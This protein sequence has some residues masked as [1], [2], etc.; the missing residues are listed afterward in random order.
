LKDP[1]SGWRAHALI[2]SRLSHN[3][4]RDVNKGIDREDVLKPR[5]DIDVI[6]Q[7]S[8][9]GHH[10]AVPAHVMVRHFSQNFSVIFH[11]SQNKRMSWGI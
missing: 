8:Q 1:S 4:A 11:W 5:S 6:E 9:P 2:R 10:T 3:G 7:G